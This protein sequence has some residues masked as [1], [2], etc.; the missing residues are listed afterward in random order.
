MAIGEYEHKCKETFNPFYWL[1][2]IIFLPQNA[3]AYVGGN[4]DGLLSKVFNFIYWIA[5]IVITVSVGI[6]P[7]EVRTFLDKLFKL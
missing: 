7:E 1:K 5:G 4:A 3:I 2:I 6:Y